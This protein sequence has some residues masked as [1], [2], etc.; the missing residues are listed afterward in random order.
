MR[1]FPNYTLRY[2]ETKEDI[3]DMIR[4]IK[5]KNISEIILDTETTGVHIKLDKPFLLQFG[6]VEG[7]TVY[8]FEARK[9]QLKRA[10]YAVLK[11]VELKKIAL[12]GHNLSFDLHMLENV[13]VEIP[14]IKCI[15]TTVCIRLAHDALTEAN[16]GPPLGLKE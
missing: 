2:L 13:G 11:L 9:K 4:E 5:H 3:L 1:K 15:D 8:V 16:G 7:D 6:Y 14:D 10:A 12:V